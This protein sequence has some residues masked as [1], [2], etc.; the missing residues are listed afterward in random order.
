M[1]LDQLLVEHWKELV[2]FLV[3]LALIAGFVGGCIYG[4]VAALLSGLED[5]LLRKAKAKRWARSQAAHKARMCGADAVGRAC[6][7]SGDSTA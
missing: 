1:S 3:E 2:P 6:E 4:G 7:T 5:Y